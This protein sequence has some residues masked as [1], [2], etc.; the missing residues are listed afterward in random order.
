MKL[1]YV[2]V[3]VCVRLF[4]DSRASPLRPIGDVT[5]AEI[6]QA[7]D[8]NVLEMNQCKLEHREVLKKCQ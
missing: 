4:A 2:P 8:V 3:V 7:T 5:E 1:L 6:H